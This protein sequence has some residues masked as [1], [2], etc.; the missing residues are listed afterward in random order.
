MSG[1]Q[2]WALV[3]LIAIGPS[4]GAAS[5]QVLECRGVNGERVFVDR[6]RCPDAAAEIALRHLPLPP[7]APISASQPTESTPPRR[8]RRSSSGAS[9]GSASQVSFRCSTRERSWYQHTPCR[10]D[11]RYAA[12][13]KNR[14]GKNEAGVRQ[15]RV[16]RELACSE[17]ARPAAVLRRGSERDERAGPYAKATGRDPCS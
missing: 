9:Y 6:A 13:N 11:S 1:R 3:M 12:G 14:G 8:A 10:S 7:P 2:L 15:E 17:I 4:A 16:S 5:I